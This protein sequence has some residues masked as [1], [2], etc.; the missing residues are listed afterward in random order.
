M[1][2]IQYAFL[3]VVSLP[4][5][6]FGF[7]LAPV[8]PFFATLKMGK[9]D[10]GSRTG[11]G[12]FLPDWLWWFQT[13]DNDLDG[14]HGWK[15]EHW[16]WRYAIPIY[17]LRQY[18]G[19]VGWLLRNPA[20]SFAV[21]YIPGDQYRWFKGDRGVKDNDGAKEG[22]LYVES[23]D[24]FQFVYCKQIPGTQRCIWVNLGWN[25]RALVDPLVVPPIEY[26]AT[27]VFSPRISGFRP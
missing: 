15:T 25:I 10:N 20:Y 8:L 3:A 17:W 23:H 26:Q 2:F 5:T 18:V 4:I 14:D 19:R 7:L 27:F 12:Y 9:L 22:W 21:R 24:L 6:L 1:K 13:P 11:M 16:Q